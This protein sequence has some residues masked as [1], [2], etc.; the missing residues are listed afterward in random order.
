VKIEEKR[1]PSIQLTRRVP[2]VLRNLGRLMVSIHLS[3]GVTSDEPE[4]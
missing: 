2:R 3:S 1:A 4:R